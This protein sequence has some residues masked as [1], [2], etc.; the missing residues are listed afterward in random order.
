MPTRPTTRQSDTIAV[1]ITTISTLFNDN[2]GVPHLCVS[3][4]LKPSLRFKH[5][6]VLVF[7]T[8]STQAIYGN[9]P[10]FCIAL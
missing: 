1:Y 5:L 4:G 7:K 6:K 3:L 9:V 2:G 10:C 8:H